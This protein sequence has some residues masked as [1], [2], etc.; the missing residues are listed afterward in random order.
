MMRMRERM[1]MEVK[2]KVDVEGARTVDGVER[3]VDGVVGVERLQE[4]AQVPPAARVLG[5]P[6]KRP[7]LEKEKKRI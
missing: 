3:A 2:R 5:S 6:A 7:S 4:R 1:R